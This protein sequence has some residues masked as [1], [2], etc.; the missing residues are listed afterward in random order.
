MITAHILFTFVLNNS[1]LYMMLITTCF[2]SG[3]LSRFVIFLSF[4]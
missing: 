4:I 1:R 3:E 2:Y